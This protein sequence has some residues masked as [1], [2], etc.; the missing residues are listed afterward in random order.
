MRKWKKKVSR[1]TR[2]SIVGLKKKGKMANCIGERRN[3]RMNVGVNL[4]LL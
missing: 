1:I 3:V 2:M 4:R